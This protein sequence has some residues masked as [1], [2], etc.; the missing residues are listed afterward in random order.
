[1]ESTSSW[2]AAYTRGV[3]PPSS[4]RSTAAPR[5]TSAAMASVRPTSMANMSAVLPSFVTRSTT[6][7]HVTNAATASSLP[8]MAAAMRAVRAPVVSRSTRAPHSHSAAMAA[9][10]P[11]MVAWINGVWASAPSLLGSAPTSISAEMV[12][13]SPSTAALTSA[14]TCLPPTARS[15]STPSCPPWETSPAMAAT[16]CNFMRAEAHDSAVCPA[17]SPARLSA[18]KATSAPARMTTRMA[19]TACAS[20][21]SIRIL[22]PSPLTCDTLAPRPMSFNTASTAAP[23]AHAI[24][25]A[26]RRLLVSWS[27]CPPLSMSA[28]IVPKLFARAAWMS[29]VYPPEVSKSGLPPP[30]ISAGMGSSTPRTPHRVSAV[31]PCLF[32]WLATALRSNGV[33]P[34]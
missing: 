14:E 23:C 28:N 16:D 11:A 30:R 33:S 6:A 24:P 4:S 21:A 22:M 9:G 10:C 20:A 7:P 32:S 26:V 19:S 27:T 13:T 18:R 25:S 12:C 5:R 15:P 1:M 31:W 29:A 3:T 8:Y 2:R 17:A 34:P